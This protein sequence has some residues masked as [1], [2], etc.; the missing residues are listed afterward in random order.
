MAP[1]IIFI[2]ADMTM[3]SSIES[4][5]GNRRDRYGADTKKQKT[6]QTQ[7]HEMNSEKR[8]WSVIFLSSRCNRITDRVT[9][10]DN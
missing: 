9:V 7:T 1:R 6:Q 2:F 8:K 10:I 3:T 4:V 5:P